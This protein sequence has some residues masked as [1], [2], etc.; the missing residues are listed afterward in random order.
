MKFLL[1]RS[2]SWL[3]ALLLA[4]LLPLAAQAS[5]ADIMTAAELRPGMRGYAKTVVEGTRIGTFDLEILGVFKESDEDDGKIIAQAS[6]PL[7]DAVGGVLQGMSGSPVYIDGKLIGA[8]SGGWKEIDNR[9][10]IIT[11]IADMLKVW[12]LPDAKSQSKIKQ[13]D[14]KPPQPKEKK[15]PAA[16]AKAPAG[17]KTP[18]AGEKKAQKDGETQEKQPP[19]AAQPKPPAPA[20]K[21][22]ERAKPDGG[23]AEAPKAL[24]TPLLVSGFSAPG[25]RMLEEKLAPFQIAPYAAGGQ[26][27]GGF[28]AGGASLEP[29]SA[30]GVQLVRGDISMAAIG[31][32]TLVEDGKVLAFGHPF[33]RKGNVNYFMTDAEI[34]AT[35]SGVS[36]GFKIGSPGRMLGRI[37]QDRSS[38]V[39]G[40]IGAYPSV[41]PLE[42]R[43]EDVQ[44]KK[45]KTYAM[46]IAYDEDLA[47]ALVASMVYN[48]ID[49]TIDRVGDGTASV[50]FEIMTSGAPGG[51][52]KRDNM[53]Y[54]AQDVG[55]QAIGEIFQAMGLLASNAMEEADIVSVKVN[56]KIDEARKT[57][58]I[59]EA[60]PDKASVKAGETV[61]L[62]LR[63]KPYRAAE[64]LLVVPYTIP[65]QQSPGMLNLEVRGGGLVSLAQLLMQQQ[66]I[67]LSA[68]EDKTKPLQT[69]VKE[70]LETNKNNE[71]VIAPSLMPEAMNPAAAGAA[72]PAPPKA[73]AAKAPEETAQETAAP[74]K[75]SAQ[76][77]Q[78]K[79][80]TRYIIDNVV[81]TAIQV[82]AK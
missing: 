80:A 43:V 28:A 23:K 37:N 75:E 8:V 32:V 57:A 16:Q 52:L 36:A 2:K 47:A 38:A 39:A 55:P 14:L 45:Q 56:V 79:H 73:V 74:A 34:V 54:N 13:V 62:K 12:N 76:Q 81:R 17:E 35:A 4:C 51:R 26:S 63:L 40:V 9:T 71:I 65:K 31:T 46:Q 3:V 61:R 25:L 72:R 41:I 53:F 1:K 77:A 10:C 67:D 7:I 59:V 27:A 19:K 22:P 66:G 48:A 42:V 5:A 58:S 60:T 68:E 44:S 33:L 29:G 24:S 20:K 6:G 30:I 69:M 15:K 11:P 50:A 70:F 49:K 64:E 18:L 78:S 82:T 21:A